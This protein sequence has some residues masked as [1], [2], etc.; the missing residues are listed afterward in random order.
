MMKTML[1]LNNLNLFLVFKLLGPKDYL[2]P[3]IN[4]LLKKIITIDFLL[5]NGDLLKILVFIF[6]DK[7]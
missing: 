5:V 2:K 3:R 1:L 6:F 4:R 7:T